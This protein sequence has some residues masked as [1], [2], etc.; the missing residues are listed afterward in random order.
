MNNIDL[1]I[2]NYSIGELKTFLKLPKNYT[3]S[4]LNKRV[5]E[6]ESV[7][8][9]SEQS[10]TKYETLN[11]INQAKQILIKNE[12]P[13]EKEGAQYN[14]Y[15]SNSQNSKLFN[16]NAIDNP[17]Q[18]PI[19]NPPINPNSNIGQ[20]LDPGS[21]HQSMETTYIENNSPLKYN[22]FIKNYV[23]NTLY[24]D[25]YFGTSSNNCTLTFPTTIKNVISMSLSALQ[26]QNVMFTISNSN[27]TDQIYIYED[28]TNNKG[29]VII[30]EGTYSYL[31]FP[32]ILANAINQQIIEPGSPNRF[33]VSINPNTHFTTISNSTYTF[34]MKIITLYPKK[35]KV[36]YSTLN[37]EKIEIQPEE[38]F[39]S[40]G[41]I[42]G[43]RKLE[44]LNEM[45]YTSESVYQSERYKYIY[46]LVNDYVGNQTKNT[47]A[48]FPQ[49]MLDD[50][51]LA[52]IP[53]TSEKFSTTFTDGS[54]YIYRTR[55]YN[56]PVDINKISIQLINPMGQ[57]ADIQETD[58]SFCLQIETIADM[59]K[60][61]I[62][63]SAQI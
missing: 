21:N 60:K 27:H 41:Y 42:M 15:N 57:I 29:I 39:N 31:E 13:E 25:N 59:T 51:I 32:M 62:Y 26:Y 14:P 24:R 22:R 63:K 20:I 47:V 12:R 58:F 49:F 19:I 9:S 18:I 28:T 55:N 10:V 52:L 30:P 50:D 45:S 3:N 6:M 8:S 56:G 36:D 4:D 5:S 11:F 43:Y 17:T 7:V 38:F 48:V 53:I 23:L 34:T 54:T 35:L 44:Y 2:D 61:F 46:F 16:I 1:N 33:S 40:L 37:Y